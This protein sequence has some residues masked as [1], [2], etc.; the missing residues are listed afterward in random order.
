MPHPPSLTPPLV[1]YMPPSDP[2]LS[3]LYEDEALL[4]IDKPSGL[5]SV[6][7]K[8]QEHWDCVEHR[9]RAR[10]DEAFIVH[11]LDM[12][13]S[14]LMVLARTAASL[15]NLGRQFEKR[16][17]EKS[18]IARVWGPVEGESGHVD[19]PLI[20]DWPRRPKQKVC[21][22][23]GKVAVTDWQVIRRDARSTLVRLC[24]HTGRSH[25]LRVH[26]L[27]LGHAI[28]GDR[29]YAEGEALASGAR[30]MLHANSLRLIHPVRGEWMTFE[31]PCPFEHERL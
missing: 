23:Q 10:F 5:L 18:Y 30:L 26:M 24:P 21:F 14:G 19:L 27:S 9:A 20:C 7:G 16:K 3:V 6:P 22:E 28:V 2:Y 31:S 17:V 29:F 11:R 25:Q 12:D 8:A 1:D 13:T 4:I 15:R